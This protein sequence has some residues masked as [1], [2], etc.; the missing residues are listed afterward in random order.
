MS[1]QAFE[2]KSSTTM[3]SSTEDSAQSKR[4]L[5]EARQVQ[6][7]EQAKDMEQ[8]EDKTLELDIPYSMRRKAQNLEPC[9]R[10][11][12]TLKETLTYLRHGYWFGCKTLN[13]KC[14]VQQSRLQFV[15]GCGA[16][17]C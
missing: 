3:C 7:G 1:R 13:P 5:K 17:E 9:A 8:E 14:S 16:S 11:S 10:S 12:Q 15:L 4:T 6:H 2:P